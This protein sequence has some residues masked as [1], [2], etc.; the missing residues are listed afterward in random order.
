[1]TTH[2]GHRD[3]AGRPP[4]FKDAGQRVN[5]YLPKYQIKFLKRSNNMSKKIQQLIDNEILHL[6]D[7][8]YSNV[9]HNMNDLS[10]TSH[11]DKKINEI[12]N[13]LIEG[14]IIDST[15]E[16]LTQEWIEYDQE[17]DF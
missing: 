4:K 1:M 3:G 17:P 11:Y 6:A 7:Q 9:Y 5:V 10:D 14:D 16:S 15:V 8:I 13:W 2:G 12:Y